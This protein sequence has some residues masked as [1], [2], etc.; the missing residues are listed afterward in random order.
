[1][2]KVYRAVGMTFLFLFALSATAFAQGTQVSGTVTS[3][4]TGEK[5]WGVTV[6]VK[7]TQTQTVSDQQGKYALIVPSNAVLTF[8]QIGF[9][10]KEAPVNGQTTVDVTL[11]QA[12][13]MLQEVVVTGYTSQRRSDITGAVSSVNLD[14]TNQQS[15]AS[16]LQRLDG[17]VPGVTINSSGSPASRSTV[18]I[19]GVSSFHDNDPLYII[20]GTP[21]EDSYLNFLNP[22]DIGQIQVLKDASSASIYGSRASNGVIIIETKKGRPGGRSATLDL[23]TGVATPTRGYD[24]IVMTD[25]LQYFQVIKRSYHNAGLGIPGDARSLYGDT[26]NPSLPA[27]TYIDPSV[28]ILTTDAY[29]RPLTV[30]P[31][32]YSYPNALV[33][34]G[35]SGSG[36]DWWKAVFGSGQFSDANLSLAGGGLDNSYNVSF[37]YLKQNGTAAYSQFERGGVRVNT[38]F[39]INKL[40]VGENISVSRE[41]GYG[42]R[43][44][45]EGEDGIVG[46]NI[47]MQ[48][49]VPVY[50]VGGNFASGKAAGLGN[51]TNPLKYAWARRFDR[52][53]ND[54]AIGN[55]FSSFAIRPALSVRS[56]FSFNLTQSQFTGFNP[57]TFE[58]AEANATNG[59]NQ[60]DGRSTTWTFTN[61]LTY[62]RTFAARHN[63]NLLLGQEA[64]SS[65]GRF[66]SGG[67]S[68]LLND[69]LADRYIDESLGQA[70]TKTVSS[71]GYFDRLLSFFGKADY[72]Y[73]ERYYASVTVRRDGSSKF[74]EGHRWGTFPAF[75]VGWRLS[76]ES[77]FPQDGFFSNVM[78]RFGYGVTGNQNIPGGRIVAKFGG[79]TGDTF[80]DIGGSGTSI[81]PGF[82]Q[83]ALGNAN[84]QWEEQKSGNVGVDLEFLHGR[85]N[86]TADIYNRTTDK[87]LFD[88]R[89]P[90]TAGAANPAIQ[91]IGKM[92]NKGI[93]FSVAYSGTVGAKIW[94]IAFNGSHYKNKI[95]QI[96]GQID[97][98]PGPG[99]PQVTRIGNPI[100]NILGQPIGTFYGKVAN[101][102]WATAAEAL[103]HKTDSLGGCATPPCQTNAVVG[104]IR[105]ED[106]NG[107]GVIDANDRTVIG[108]P[109]PDFTAGIDLA[110]RSGAWDF[111]AT[112]F[113]SFG[114]QIY[115]AQK[116]FYVFRD[117]E[118]NVVKDRLTDSFCITGDEGCT[119]PGD[120][121]AKYPRLNQNDL[122]S[123]EISS[124]FIESATYVRL[125]TVQIGWTIPA[126]LIRWLPSGRLY[127]QGENLFTITGY[128][129]LDPSLPARDFTGA[130]GDIRDQ[131]RNVDVGVYPTNRTFTFGIS[132]SF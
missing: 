99:G 118:T 77:F 65:T 38:A 81:L 23:R 110:F 15:S 119:N 132:T 9:R 76:R 79:G 6:R 58:N 47:L 43:G 51:N 7:G 40:T 69:A 32:G 129:G 90:S 56:Q 54:R 71:S 85:G 117:F 1:M 26:L 123:G 25:P 41:S 93:D 49:V 53:I 62:G 78:L 24:D 28:A 107:D 19:R 55:V 86:F 22:A 113:G 42:G 13:T 39:N 50:D 80:Y 130:S 131:F 104:G 8:A 116:D 68:G 111:S 45:G 46:K 89:P 3:A 30:D 74:A 114:G 103:A 109:H 37:N 2:H 17:R 126:N 112:V 66:M 108:S 105:Y 34:P 128:P 61:T 59:I 36:T 11:E 95:L 101:G 21:V 14:P 94:S 44:D 4:T 91:N 125:R 63:L 33:M 52:N 64:N 60:N 98:F 70:S 29:G 92:S 67:I 75:N 73:A 83:I 122:G 121:S 16:V 31:N 106:I 87:L 10:G 127:I 27:F 18:R 115:D 97:Q 72:N 102:Y 124:F 82:R 57:T 96:D 5:L 20:D 88:P 12:P 100:M 120:Q 35:P 48:P 84:L